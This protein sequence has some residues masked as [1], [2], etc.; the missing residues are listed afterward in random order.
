MKKNKEI[1]VLY[2]KGCKDGFGAAWAAWRKF[3]ARAKYIGVNHGDKLP[4]GL[5]RKEV[6]MVDFTYSAKEMQW[7]L[8][9]CKKV[10]AL[11]HHVS[12][13][14]ATM[15]AHDYRYNVSH[16]GATL[17]WLYFFPNKK[18][19]QI[20]RYL[21]DTDIWRFKMQ[22]TRE[23]IASI[24][25]Y[26]QD[27]RIWSKLAKEIE[28]FSTRKIHIMRGKAILQYQGQLI[29]KAVDE[30]EEVLFLK[31]RVLV[32]NSSVLISVIG[33]KLAQKKKSFGIVWRRSKGLILVS[34]R[35][36]PSFNVSKI[37]A[38]F[39]GGGHK[40]AAAFTLSGH[41]SLPWKRIKK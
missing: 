3:G 10:V 35:S 29:K 22:H 18:T 30:A 2:H 36:I 38:H 6:Y 39:G 32:S 17:A 12:S 7:L 14:A 13:M 1:V 40:N 28:K 31:H 34:L 19:P 24:H 11:D 5:A 20:L 25:T 15:L 41:K 21:E 16:S 9:I 26:G 4:A 8:K 23:I 27:F 33:H 37:A